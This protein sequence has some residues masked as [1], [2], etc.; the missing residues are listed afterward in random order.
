MYYKLRLIICSYLFTDN[1]IIMTTL[2]SSTF[3]YKFLKYIYIYIQQI[4]HIDDK[5]N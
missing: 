5:N 3:K 4:E 1:C 2:R